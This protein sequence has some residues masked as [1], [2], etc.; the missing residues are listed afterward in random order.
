MHFQAAAISPPTAE[1]TLTVP[2]LE[3]GLQEDR[4]WS[5]TVSGMAHTLVWGHLAKQSSA[6]CKLLSASY[7]CLG[8]WS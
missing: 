5:R 7:C 3:H 4:G 1:P 8:P 2:L 6:S